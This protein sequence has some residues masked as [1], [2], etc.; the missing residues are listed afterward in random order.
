ML[1]S[2]FL[3]K[4]SSQGMSDQY[5]VIWS[6]SPL[7][8]C[9]ISPRLSHSRKIPFVNVSNYPILHIKR[10]VNVQAVKGKQRSIY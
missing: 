1:S 9:F 5:C 10:V 4:L 6:A 7:L 3:S 8:S 2:L